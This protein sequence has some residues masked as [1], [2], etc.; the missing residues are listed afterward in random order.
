MQMETMYAAHYRRSGMP[1]VIDLPDVVSGLCEAAAAAHPLRYAAAGQQRR[2][3]ERQE[4]E[5]L[6]AFAAILTITTSDA[7]RLLALG[8]T[9]VHVPLAI[10]PP[11]DEDLAP[12]R[13]GS[14][15]ARPLRVLFVASFA[16]LPNRA[17][18]AFLLDRVVTALAGRALACELTLAGRRA[19]E[20]AATARAAGSAVGGFGSVKVDFISDPPDLAPLYRRADVVVAPLAFGGGTK[21]KTLEAMAWGLPVVGTPQAFTGLPENLRG[22]AWLETPLDADVLA[23]TLARLAADSALRE[24]LGRAGRA[25]VLAEHTQAHVDA[26]MDAVYERVL[27]AAAGAAGGPA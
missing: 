8:L 26:L 15:V 6:A 7:A 1:A 21:N 16:H 9:S 5:M 19:A 23:R 25:Y 24:R 27:G 4:R 10:T 20:W 13:S 22:V 11:P 12:G 14:P 18:A 2:A 3:V 17:A